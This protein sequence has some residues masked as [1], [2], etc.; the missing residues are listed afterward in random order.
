MTAKPPSDLT[1]IFPP[2]WSP[3][4]PPL[5]IASLVGWLRGKGQRISARDSNIA[6][7]D[8]LFSPIAATLIKKEILGSI[9][10]GF[11][12]RA[13]LSIFDRQG[14]FAADLDLLRPAEGPGNSVSET[15]FI[16]RTALATKSVSSYLAA[17][18]SVLHDITISLDGLLIGSG[19]NTIEDVLNIVERPHSVIQR[20]CEVE[21]NAILQKTP[22]AIY[23]ISCIGQDQLPF[24]LLLGKRLREAGFSVIV[25]GTVLPRLFQAG[26]LP[27]N[28]FERYFDLVISHEGE[29]PLQYLLEHSADLQKSDLK[30]PGAI[31]VEHGALKASKP[32]PPLKSEDVPTPDF[33]DFVLADYLSPVPTLPVLSSRG[34]YWGKCE[35]CHHGMIYGESYSASPPKSVSSTIRELSHAYGVRSFAF[36]DEA[37]PPRMLRWLGEN[38]PRAA[39]SGWSF[40]ALVKFEKYYTRADFESAASVGFRTL[41]F[42]LESASERVLKLMKKHIPLPVTVN[43]LKNAADAGIWVHCFVFFGFPGETNEEAAITA[44]FVAQSQHLDSIGV[45]VFELEHGAPISRRSAEFGIDVVK[46]SDRNGSVYYDYDIRKGIS[47]RRALEWMNDLVRMIQSHPRYSIAG[48][49]KR[50]LLLAVLS[51]AKKDTLIHLGQKWLDN[52]VDLGRLK[53]SDIVSFSDPSDGDLLLINR[54]ALK[55]FPIS[56]EAAGSLLA[57]FENLPNCEEIGAVTPEWRNFLSIR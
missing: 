44:D 14:D 17:I 4:R 25:G 23:G 42:G 57:L 28:W 5:G 11:D 32:S 7:Y 40:E 29:V 54:P 38:L 37:L 50:D 10:S 55:F 15:E 34:C 12:S 26:R 9:R 51:Q 33:S 52:G 43:I 49:I 27:A 6:F 39:E 19:R 35:F 46:A 16:T 56:G 53:L 45:G 8:Y 24:T 3:F 1:L 22:G 2:Q 47:A 20:F 48:W 31:F 36:H 21:V 18:S 30:V 41:S 13:L